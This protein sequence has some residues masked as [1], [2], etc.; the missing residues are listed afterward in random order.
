[1]PVVPAGAVNV[2][3]RV[4]SPFVGLVL[5]NL[6][7]YVPPWQPEF[8]TLSE[9]PEAVQPNRL[10]VSKPPLVI[11]P[12]PPLGFTVTVTVAVCVLLPSVPVT[13][14]VYVPAPTDVPTVTLSVADPPAATLVGLTEA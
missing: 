14:T 10:P 4:L 13:V 12:P 9:G 8:T 3:V 11:P 7:Q 5:P 6:A 1:M 2:W